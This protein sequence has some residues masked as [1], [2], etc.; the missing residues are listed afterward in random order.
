MELHLND[1]ELA[2]VALLIA[3]GLI[4]ITITTIRAPERLADALNLLKVILLALIGKRRSERRL[5]DKEK[6]GGDSN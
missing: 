4:W 2:V 3:S 6:D 5:K 1:S